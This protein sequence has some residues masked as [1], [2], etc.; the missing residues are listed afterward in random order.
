MP[1]EAEQSLRAIAELAGAAAAESSINDAGYSLMRFE[2]PQFVV[3]VFQLN[4]TA[5]PTSFNVWDSLSEAQVATGDIKGA[6]QS[7]ESV[8]ALDPEFGPARERLRTLREQ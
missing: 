8:L 6:I 3:A 7:C 5:F 4:A 1:D 2:Q